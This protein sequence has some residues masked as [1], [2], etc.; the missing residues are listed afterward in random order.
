LTQD[1]ID[2]A[3][4][5]KSAVTYNGNDVDVKEIADEETEEIKDQNKKAIKAALNTLK[6][7]DDEKK[8][9]A[10]AAAQPAAV[11][12]SAPANTTKATVLVA[13]ADPSK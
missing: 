11:Q 2:G 5:E 13:K 1:I 7:G 3:L 8:P 9:V 10:A 6:K 4:T 12:A